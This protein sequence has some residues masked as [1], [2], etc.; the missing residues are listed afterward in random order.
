MLASLLAAF[1]S[2]ET[3]QIARRVRRAAIAYLLAGIALLIGLGFLVGAGY[4]AAA[5]R[6]GAINAALGFAAGFLLLAAIIVLA[7]RIVS[8]MR[9]RSIARKRSSELTTIGAAA[10]LAVLPTLLRGKGGLTTL[11]APALAVLA[12]AIYRENSKAGPDKDDG[13]S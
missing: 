10:V 7:H 13:P 4:T 3:F 5:E 1:A 6:Y 11:L 2:G 9:A 12:Y 8:G